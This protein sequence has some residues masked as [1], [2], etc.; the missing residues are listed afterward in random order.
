MC[1]EPRLI[2]NRTELLVAL[3]FWSIPLMGHS[4]LRDSSHAEQHYY[5]ML[6]QP[7]RR[8]ARRYSLS[9]CAIG[10]RYGYIILLHFTGPA[11]P[12]TARM[13]STPQGPFRCPLW[14]YSLSPFVIGGF[15]RDDSPLGLLLFCQGDER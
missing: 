1:V 9:P 10:A 15:R 5:T 2:F 8:R 4:C 6:A 14:V 3:D 13:H 7:N 12:I 11:V